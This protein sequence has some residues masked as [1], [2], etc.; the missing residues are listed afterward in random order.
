MDG[1]DEVILIVSKRYGLGSILPPSPSVS[2]E[3]AYQKSTFMETFGLVLRSEYL[4]NLC[5]DD[6]I[7]ITSYIGA[8][9]G[10]G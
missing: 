3:I 1:P 4:L 8:E 10:E 9:V 2:I 5:P 7:P 6:F